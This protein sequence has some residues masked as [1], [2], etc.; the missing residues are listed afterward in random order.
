M[1]VRVEYGVRCAM[2]THWPAWSGDN[3]MA[4]TRVGRWMLAHWLAWE[5]KTLDRLYACGPHTVV[6]RTIRVPAK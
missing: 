1:N 3:W 4:W 6:R 2:E 5:S